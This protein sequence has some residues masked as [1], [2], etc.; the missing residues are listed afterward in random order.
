MPCWRQW[1]RWK[2]G[3]NLVVLVKVVIWLVVLAAVVLEVVVACMVACC[4]LDVKVEFWG[5]WFVVW[6]L[7]LRIPRGTEVVRRD[8]YGQRMQGG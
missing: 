7:L 8:S 3:G 4:D 5:W 1:L 2:S 6:E